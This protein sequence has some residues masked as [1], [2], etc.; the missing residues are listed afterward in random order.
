MTS[1]ALLIRLEARKGRENDVARFL[2]DEL[3]L[4]RLQPDAAAWFALRFGSRSFGVF[5]T[6]P[7]E[8]RQSTEVYARMADTLK[9][10]SDGLFLRPP[11][12]ERAEVLSA[13]RSAGS[14]RDTTLVLRRRRTGPGTARLPPGSV[15]FLL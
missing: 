1:T 9:T 6:M 14:R 2:H 4:A 13:E 10:K 11:V 12:I 8:N 5:G 15:C 7:G 3:A